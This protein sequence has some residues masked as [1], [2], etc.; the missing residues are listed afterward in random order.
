MVVNT[1]RVIVIRPVAFGLRVGGCVPG[2][3][4]PWGARGGTKWRPTSFGRRSPFVM[5]FGLWDGDC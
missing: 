4:P 1:E 3:V 5:R 2:C